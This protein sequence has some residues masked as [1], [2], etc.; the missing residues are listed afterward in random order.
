MVRFK[1]LLVI[2]IL[3]AMALSFAPAPRSYADSSACSAEKQKLGVCPGSP[4]TGGVTNGGS[5]DLRAEA[6]GGS[7]GT[8]G[9]P[10]RAGG[11][12]GIQTPGTPAAPKECAHGDP[13]KP[14]I[15]TIPC[16][17]DT[18]LPLARPGT[19]TTPCTLCSP[20]TIVRV[21]D[22]QNFPAYPAPTTMEPGGW[23]I[24]GL[25]ANFWAKAS[26]QITEGLLLGQPAQVMF[27]APV[28]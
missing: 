15:K 21:T 27:T 11:R 6:I 4:A 16:G 20:D 24:V 22:L 25:P 10:G 14:G 5:V 9:A 17:N 19:A 8:S 2:G 13:N 12:A 26:A 18:F 7:G 3:T 28:W 1:F 23:A